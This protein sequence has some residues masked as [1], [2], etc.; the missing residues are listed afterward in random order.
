MH[1]LK[2]L[3]GSEGFFI[4]ENTTADTME[5][6]MKRQVTMFQI[7]QERGRISLTTEPKDTSYF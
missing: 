2:D 3:F 1:K 5:Y 4:E 7:V 6:L